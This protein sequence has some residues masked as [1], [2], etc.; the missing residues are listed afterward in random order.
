MKQLQLDLNKRLLI[1]EFDDME[2]LEKVISCDK[3]GIRFC[4]DDDE[5]TELIC[6]GS[7]LTEVIAYKLVEEM[8]RFNTN[9]AYKNYK[10]GKSFFMALESFISAIESKGMFWKDW[11]GE[12]ETFEESESRT[13]NP[14]K[15]IIFEIL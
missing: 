7:G 3:Q 10:G 6:K 14:E 4:S 12:N 8:S 13:F 11:N 15:C 2:H 1:V 9:T 5:P